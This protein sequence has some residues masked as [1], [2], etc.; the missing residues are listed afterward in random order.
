VQEGL[1]WSPDGR[2]IAFSAHEYDGNWAIWTMNPDGSSRR[3]LTHPTPVEPRGI[4]G[5]YVGAWSPDG[6]QITYSSGQFTRR[7][8]C[9]MNA[10]G[11]GVYRLTDWPGADGAVAWLPSGEIVFA[12]FRGDEPFPEWYLVKPDGTGL[13]ALPWLRSGGDPLDWIVPR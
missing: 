4:G 12:H 3:Q 9:V 8:L 5:D 2:G 6:K 1:A 11:I 10:D 7:D 13:R